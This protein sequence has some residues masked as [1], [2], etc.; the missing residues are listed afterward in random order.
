MSHAHLA[1]H[2]VL[3]RCYV[4]VVDHQV[5]YTSLERDVGSVGSLLH[6]CSNTTEED[7]LQV[8]R[9]VIGKRRLPLGLF[10]HLNRIRSGGKHPRRLHR[11][12][13]DNIAAQLGTWIQDWAASQTPTCQA[14]SL[15]A[16]S[17]LSRRWVCLAQAVWWHDADC[18]CQ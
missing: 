1:K 18:G 4:H 9:L 3:T 12:I 10:V 6:F 11:V 7:P 13:I 14:A 2:A 15:C 8:H 17:A 16:A 5:P